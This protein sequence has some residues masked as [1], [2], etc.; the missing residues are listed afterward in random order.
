MAATPELIT[1][2]EAKPAAWYICLASAK[3]PQQRYKRGRTDL[4]AA[5]AVLC[6]DVGTKADRAD[7]P[8][9]Y[10]LESSEGNLQCVWLIDPWP[11]DTEENRKYYEACVRAIGSANLSDQGAGGAYRV[12]RV[13][14]S[15]HKSGFVSRIV[16]WKPKV[17]YELPELMA[18]LGLEPDYKHTTVT[19]YDGE[20]PDD[21]D[22]PVAEWLTSTGRLGE[23]NGAWHTIP[24]PWGHNHS[25]DNIDAGYSPLGQGEYPL[26]RGFSCFHQHCAG[27]SIRDFLA[28]VVEQDGPSCD[29]AGVREFERQ[30]IERHAQALDIDQR[31]ELLEATAPYALAEMLPNVLLTA[32]GKP[33][34]GQLPTATNVAKVAKV[35]GVRVRSNMM[36]HEIECDFEDDQLNALV[37]TGTGREARQLL[38]DR[39][40]VLGI[41]KVDEVI[42]V[43]GERRRFSPVCEWI[44]SVEWDGHSRFDD[45]LDT[46]T[47][48]PDYENLTAVYLRRWLVQAMQAFHNWE[49]EP[50]AI[51]HVFTLIGPQGCGKTTWC[52]SLVP[53]KWFMRGVYL[54]LGGGTV[55][56]R[57]A[58]RKATGSPI[59]ELGELETTFSKSDAGHQKNFLSQTRDKYRPSYGHTEIEY[60]RTTAYVATANRADI[61]SDPSGSRRFWMVEVDKCDGFHS[62]D[63]Q[64]MWAEVKT[65]WAAGEQWVLTGDEDQLR[66][67]ASPEFEYHSA[68]KG[69]L[70]YYLARHEG[71]EVPMNVSQVLKLLDLPQQ[72][73]NG[74]DIKDMLIR[75]Y[76]KPRTIKGLQRAWLIPT[77]LKGLP[78]TSNIV[79]LKRG[80]DRT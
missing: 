44:D 78:D 50:V 23:V 21:I 25:D 28:W 38:R 4:V 45:L 1:R 80:P 24:C 2:I 57:D 32:A 19:T 42:N 36:T 47:P 48:A 34:P 41:P 29:I 8:Y 76:G 33:K 61:Q 55:N 65:W 31:L 12:M 11:L 73:G 71:N 3:A 22:D 10:E 20:L 5:Y 51:E 72:H 59:V 53:E 16:K 62:V 15:L 79:P 7:V 9:S 43:I 68:A 58:T 49:G 77:S 18:K 35:V 52:A 75:L 26:V 30:A 39:C 54:D 56:D 17:S 14:G 74:G 67:V 40:M 27:R 64:Q 69:A 60:P 6:D 37:G 70:D 63:M 46:I 13:P 66:I